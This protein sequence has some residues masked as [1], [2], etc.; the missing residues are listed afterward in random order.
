MAQNGHTKCS[1]RSDRERG[2]TFA[3]MQYTP[4]PFSEPHCR[5][6]AWA[7]RCML[8]NNESIKSNHSPSTR[9]NLPCYKYVSIKL[10]PELPLSII[11]Q[12]LHQEH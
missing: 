10:N 4:V 1:W 8:T 12:Q 11:Q 7:V 5:Q 9:F 3:L 6:T 2:G